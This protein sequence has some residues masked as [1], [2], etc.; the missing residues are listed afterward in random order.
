MMPRQIMNQVAHGYG[1][2]GPPG[3]CAPNI[4]CLDSASSRPRM[5]KCMKIKSAPMSAP[6]AMYGSMLE[7]LTV[8]PTAS[9]CLGSGIRS[10]PL[11]W[12]SS[13]DEYVDGVEENKEEAKTNMEKVLA[14]ISLQTAVGHFNEDE[15][16]KT[17]IGT[18]F[19]VFKTKCV[20][21]NIDTKVWLTALIIA[22]IEQN[23]PDEKDRWDL[24]VEKARDWLGSTEVIVAASNYLMS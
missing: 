23:F 6:G 19:E 20:D 17:I 3:A 12:S 4:V 13:T 9:A 5:S 14:L 22:Y 16:I 8:T 15:I 11:S 18:K 21:K 1:G 2:M 7:S 24:I 10:V